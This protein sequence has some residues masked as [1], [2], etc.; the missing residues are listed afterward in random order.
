[1]SA[2]MC[3]LIA[4]AHFQGAVGDA[5]RLCWNY[6]NFFQPTSHKE[7]DEMVEVWLTKLSY[8]F[9]LSCAH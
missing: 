1:M 7:P 2:N 9:F 5:D 3:D 4:Q 6:Q 8:V